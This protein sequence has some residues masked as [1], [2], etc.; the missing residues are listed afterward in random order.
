MK[1]HALA[2]AIAGTA[3]GCAADSEPYLVPAAFEAELTAE[4]DGVSHLYVCVVGDGYAVSQG[5]YNNDCWDPGD[6]LSGTSGGTPLVFGPL[7][8]TGGETGFVT[9]LP[10]DEGGTDVILDWNAIYCGP[11][12]AELALPAKLAITSPQA[13]SEVAVSSGTLP[14]RWEPWGAG[15]SIEYGL[16]LLCDRWGNY[17][18]GIVIPD[19]GSFQ[20]PLQLHSDDSSCS[21]TLNLSRIQEGE[22]TQDPDSV[23]AY[24]KYVKATQ[25]RA[26]SFTVTP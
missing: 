1:T 2:L 8:D 3:A 13:G 7:D 26:V 19:T 11:A 4:G 15:G 9:T 12:H 22:L 21:V 25:H 10:G 16:D 17:Y 14:I 24:S 5:L 18:G 23:C 20:I 6:E